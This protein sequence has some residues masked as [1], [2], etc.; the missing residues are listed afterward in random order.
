MK[1]KV[2]DLEHYIEKDEIIYQEQIKEKDFKSQKYRKTLSEQTQRE[3][4]EI[5]KLK[6]TTNCMHRIIC[7]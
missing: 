6:D 3:R 2:K 5:D 4:C 7:R 1:D